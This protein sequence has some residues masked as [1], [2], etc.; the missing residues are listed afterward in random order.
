MKRYCLALDL[1]NDEALIKEYEEYHKN[2]WGEI[3]DG[4]KA[5]GILDM[6]IYR[7][8]NRMFMIIETSSD[9]DY[10]VQMEKL[11][12]L[13]RQEEWEKL[14]WKF[15]KDIISGQKWVVMNRIFKLN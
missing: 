3:L 12:K 15:Q 2:V 11:S 13:P 14:M 4:I 10:D 5:V 8:E 6:Q 7:V 1:Q 9:F